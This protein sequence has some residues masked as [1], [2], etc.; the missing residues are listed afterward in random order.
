MGK[1]RRHRDF[2]GEEFE[3]FDQ[4]KRWEDQ[5]REMRRR[6]KRKNLDVPDNFWSPPEND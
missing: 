2:D 6:E 5:Q 1:D 3:E 4:H